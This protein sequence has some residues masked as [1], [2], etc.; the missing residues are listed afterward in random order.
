MKGEANTNTKRMEAPV[1]RMSEAEPVGNKSI[2]EM[3]K[4][5]SLTMDKGLEDYKVEEKRWT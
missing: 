3:V 2:E 4:Q 5:I 1:E